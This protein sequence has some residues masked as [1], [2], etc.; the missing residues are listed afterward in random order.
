M[1]LY[2][3]LKLLHVFSIVL[4]VGGMIYTLFFLRPSLGTLASP[5]RV[6]LMHDV[7][8]RFF[9][10]VLIVSTIAVASGFW[11]IGRVA[12]Q[13][14]Q[15]GGAFSWPTQWVLMAVLGTLMY[16]VFMHIRFALFKRLQ[17]AVGASDWAAG[18]A[19][20]DQ[21]RLWVSVNLVIG[22]VIIAGVY[23]K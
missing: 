20:L 9:K 3:L 21:I 5:Q 11:M 23:L 15:S 12:K 14:V 2:N 4:W 22:I 18:G 10:A 6:Q 17:R 19:A 7:L 8:A 13:T 16:L 1:M